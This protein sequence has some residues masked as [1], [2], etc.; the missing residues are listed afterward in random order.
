MASNGHRRQL[1][2]TIPVSEKEKRQAVLLAR[3]DKTSVS[4]LV[5]ALL[6][7]RH[8]TRRENRLIA[9]AA[10]GSPPPIRR[11]PVKR[12]QRRL[13][14]AASEPSQGGGAEE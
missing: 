7:E 1:R 13:L 11:K 10:G 3:K 4:K 14:Q 2:L 6:S 5:R 12:V 9:D 8:R